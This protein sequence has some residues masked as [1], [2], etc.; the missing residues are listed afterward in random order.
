MQ[1][2]LGYIG[3]AAAGAVG[4]IE[5]IKTFFKDAPSWT[6]GIVSPGISLAVAIAGGGDLHQ[7][8]TNAIMILAVSQIAYQTLIQG[9]QKIAKVG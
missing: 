2:D 7:I 4:C 5:Y 9:L 3:S 6:W 1:I 8:A